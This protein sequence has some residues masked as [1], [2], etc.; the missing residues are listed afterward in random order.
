MDGQQI[1]GLRRL[2]AFAARVAAVGDISELAETLLEAA[3]DVVKVTYAGFYFFDPATGC[4]RLLAAR[5]VTEKERLDAERTATKR[6]PIQVLRSGRMLHVPDTWESTKG[7]VDSERSFRVRSR[8]YIPVW[9]DGA[10]V[11]ALGLGSLTPNAFEASHIEM[12]SFC[13][14]M[15]GAMYSRLRSHEETRQRE[16]RLALVVRAADLGLW[17]WHVPSGRVTFSKRW[18]EMLG[19]GL[20]EIEPHI[21]SWELL[22]HPDDR[23]P[24]LA[25]LQRHLDGEVDFY[26]TEHRLRAKSGAWVWVLDAG[27]VLVRDGQG[28]PIR[29]TGIHLDLSSH[30]RARFELQEHRD[31]LEGIVAA[32]TEEL[33]RTVDRL[34]TENKNRKVVEERHR[35]A[36]R[37]LQQTSEALVLAEEAE[38]RKIAVRVH[39]GL[40]QELTLARIYLKKA[41]D[42]VENAVARRAVGEVDKLLVK[43]LHVARDITADLSPAVL[44][45]FGLFAALEDLVESVGQSQAELVASFQ[46]AR[47]RTQLSQK[48]QIL[49]YQVVKELVYNAVKHAEAKRLL[50]TC[51]ENRR[52]LVVSVEDD[53]VGLPELSSAAPVERRRGSGIGLFSI[54]ERLLNAGGMFRLGA[55][56]LGGTLVSVSLPVQAVTMEEGEEDA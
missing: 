31:Q 52:R 30:Y 34:S 8:L 33:R 54:R 26:R 13:A 18:A 56:E 7:T 15:A 50:V 21:R 20:D 22:L 2:G 44:Y 5:G 55:G 43:V 29:V 51:D 42:A 1:E 39:D 9:A 48:Q 36:R 40:G 3:S 41:A 47:K 53:G 45:Q 17:D 46:A 14:S 32:R 35:R 25:E 12:L 49:L 28:D 4:L 38:R 10:V 23:T 16:E 19:Y 6:H 27:R 24:V 37:K 11:G